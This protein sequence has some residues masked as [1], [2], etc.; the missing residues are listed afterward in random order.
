MNT[1]RKERKRKKRKRKK[2]K[3][4]KEIIIMF[5]PYSQILSKILLECELNQCW[6]GS[7]FRLYITFISLLRYQY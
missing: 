4:R 1:E 7:K 5:A 6:F 3:K 2:K